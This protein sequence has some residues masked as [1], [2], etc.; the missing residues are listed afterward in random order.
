MLILN[1]TKQLIKNLE[2]LKMR[3][4]LI[5]EGTKVKAI[6]FNGLAQPQI[7]EKVIKEETM[8]FLE[9]IAIDPI[10]KVDCGPQHNTIGGDWARKGFYGFKLPANKSGYDIILVHSN[11]VEVG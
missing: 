9:D 5:A 10:G 7:E 2:E 6:K 4:F 3:A 11:E 8:Y 1:S